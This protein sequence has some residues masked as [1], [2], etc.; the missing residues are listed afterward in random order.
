MLVSGIGSDFVRSSP[1]TGIC[2]RAAAGDCNPTTAPLQPSA[3]T[4][5]ESWK[6]QTMDSSGKYVRYTNEQVEA[7]ERVYHECPKPSS[8]RRHQLI[9]ESP[10]LANI[11]PKQIK[12]WFQNR[13]CREKQRKE[14][15]RLV[16]V[17]AKLTALNKLLMEENERLAKH[18]SQLTLENHSLRQQ[19]PSLPLTNGTHRLSSQNLLKKE[20]AVNGGDESSTQGGICVKLHGQAGVASTDTSCDSAVTGGL[21][22][23]LT[24]R[25][26]PRY[27][28]PAGLLATAEE[29]LTEFLA[30]ATGTAV[31]WIQLPG[32][33]PG[34][35]AI[36]I[37]AISH[38]CVGI[39]AR[40]CGLVAL[41]AGKVTEVLKDRPA[42]LEDCRRMEVLGALPTGNRGTIEL[43]YT[44]MYASTTLAPARD[45]C[46]LRYTT[47][48][49]DGNLV[50]CERSLTGGQNGPSMPPVQSFVRG[51]MFPSG[52][53]IRP[54]DGGG[55]IIHVV[56]HYDNG[57]WSVPE[58]LRPL[59]E[60]PA[61]LAQRSTIAALRHL[62]RLAAEESG[63]GNP[64]NGQH[65]AVLRTLGQRLAKGFKNAVNGFADD[66]WV[67][68]V[69]DGLD[70]VSVI[71]NATSQSMEGQIASDK[72][73]Y[74]LG[75]GILCAKASML[76]QNVPPSILIKFL[77]EHRSEWADY[78][79]D[80]NLAT[81]FR[82]NGNGYAPQGGGVSH[83]QLPLPLPNSG[84]HGEILEVVKLEDHSSVQHMVISRDSFLLQ[85][86]SGIDENAV[87][88][89]A[90]LIFAPVDVALTEDIPLLPSGFCIS[91]VDAN[92]LDEFDLD[93]TL[94]LASTLEGGS[95]LR[96]N[97]DSK[98]NGTSS[99]MR[100]VLTIA[101][102]FAYEVHSHEACAVMARQYLRTVVSSVQRVA[103]A[104][105][106]SRGSAPPR[107]MSANPDALSLA[108]HVL[109][110]YRLHLGLDLTRSENGGDETLFKAFWHHTDAILCCA[111]KGK[112]EFV[113]AN[114]SGLEMFETTTSSLQELDWDKTLNESDCKL[115][116]A[117]FTQ[118]LQQGYCSLP[119]GVRMSSSGRTA[120]Y[121]RALV[122]KV[123]DD[124]E[125]VECIAFLFINWSFVV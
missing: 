15:T 12:V 100:S 85:L 94:D 31:D 106:P 107:Q 86:C 116:Y 76:L 32:M 115:S 124:N 119:A 22:H 105:A 11:E 53:L 69:S 3:R 40:A 7:L 75:G 24:P 9:K 97:G 67:S 49:E 55:C 48:L 14:A 110:S 72:L 39:A 63:E 77:R 84:E 82:S 89:S 41:D 108:R 113:F 123:V 117:T 38:G 102:Q 90:Q 28:S 101:F 111:W 44:Q 59:Y 88:A 29:T 121:E 104:L 27:T 5:T 16:S 43:L 70:D 47:I 114:R 21:P 65:P 91:P 109:R 1:E 52:Y 25:H 46:T 99:H 62:R 83:V 17:N 2:R 23:H 92:V 103:M 68:T 42:W 13:R 120:T 122:W 66:G 112:P 61:V 34:P 33:K 56:D 80:A 50:I 6:E 81:S 73:L 36:G 30:K 4:M 19:L 45:Y 51:E 64:R 78:D 87:G 71:L 20:R 26:S 98:S 95:D 125:T 18:A 10:I 37:I 79:M 8:I 57:P 35:D 60:S 58:V 93:H 118:V 96:L 54:C 74:S